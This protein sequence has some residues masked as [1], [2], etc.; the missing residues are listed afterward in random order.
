MATFEE[1]NRVFEVSVGNEF[2]AEAVEEIKAPAEVTFPVNVDAPATDNDPEVPVPIE[3]P[4]TVDDVQKKFPI[5]FP[6]EFPETD[7]P[8]VFVLAVV[9]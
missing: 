6:V 9:L 3:R 2:A 7:I 5:G 1:L 4:Y 8:N